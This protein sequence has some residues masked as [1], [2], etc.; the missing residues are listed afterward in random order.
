MPTDSTILLPT[1]TRIAEAL[2]RLCPHP[3]EKNDFSSD[4]YLWQGAQLSLLPRP[5]KAVA[6]LDLLLG[7][8]HPKQILLENTHRFMRGY[9]AN[10]A[11]LWGARGMGKSS[12]V[13]AVHRHLLDQQPNGLIL[14]EITGDDLPTLMPLLEILATAP[15]PVVV[16]CDDLSFGTDDNRYKTLKSVLE[17]GLSSPDNLLFYATSNRRHLMSRD[18][19]ENERSSAI[20]P[21]EA[22]EENVSL[23]DR[24]GLWLGFHGCDEATYQHM[25]RQYADHYRLSITPETLRAAA[26]EWAIT[27]GARS[28][29]VAWQFIRDLAGQ[30]QV[31]LD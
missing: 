17:G 29:R 26:F 6:S 30:Q 19:I 12:L 7:I 3:I 28:G 24:F 25:V 22:I 27:R 21:G 14:V 4:A 9:P 10:H 5:I 1:L 31:R 20:H 15:R 13:K 8:D 11:L 2:E 18:M 23:S 16:F